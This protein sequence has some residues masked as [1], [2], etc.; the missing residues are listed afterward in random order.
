VTDDE[1]DRA[2]VRLS[3]SISRVPPDQHE[4]F[5]ARLVLLLL[6]SHPDVEAAIAAI[7]DA[8]PSG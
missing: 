8:V 2:Y 7:A 4:R 5:L 3:Q 1:L 6:A